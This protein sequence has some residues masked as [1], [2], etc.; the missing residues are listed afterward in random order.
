M[1]GVE[2][3][4]TQHRRSQSSVIQKNRNFV[5]VFTC[6][7]IGILKIGILTPT[8]IRNREQK[9]K[10]ARYGYIWAATTTP[11]PL[12]MMR[13]A[14]PGTI[15]LSPRPMVIISSSVVMERVTSPS[16]Q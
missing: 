8:K 16:T 5:A 15:T 3:T 14:L 1:R 7:G 12:N 2:A 11:S 4:T 13:L 10:Y 6:A 9:I